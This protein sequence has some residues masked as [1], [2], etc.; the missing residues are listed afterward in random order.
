MAQHSAGPWA[1]RCRAARC[2]S[3]PRD[4]APLRRGRVASLV[5][6][7][8]T[9]E[10]RSR[11]VPLRDAAFGTALHCRRGEGEG[12]IRNLDRPKCTKLCRSILRPEAIFRGVSYPQPRGSTSK[13]QSWWVRVLVP[14][15][16]NFLSNSAVVFKN[17]R[18]LSSTPIFAIPNSSSPFL[19]PPSPPPLPPAMV[20]CPRSGSG[21]PRGVVVSAMPPPLPH[22]V[23]SS[24]DDRRLHDSRRCSG[25]LW[26]LLTSGSRTDNAGEGARPVCPHR[27]DRPRPLPKRARGLGGGQGWGPAAGGRATG[28]LCAVGPSLRHRPLC[29]RRP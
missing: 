28:C 17:R 8:A 23:L 26:R 14:Q 3:G 4:R 15:F 25:G 7:G 29:P 19:T 9:A 22:S 1:R 24:G 18:L 12:E 2:V 16:G 13:Q 21:S 6:W 27:P 20:Q 10:R 11:D 5:L